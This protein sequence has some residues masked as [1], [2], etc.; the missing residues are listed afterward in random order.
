MSVTQSVY[1]N[2]DDLVSFATDITTP[3][4]TRQH[5][6]WSGS[7]DA[8]SG[9]LFLAPDAELL[10]DDAFNTPLPYTDPSDVNSASQSVD[11]FQAFG[12]DVLWDYLPPVVWSPELLTTVDTYGL[13]YFDGD[14]SYTSASGSSTSAMTSTSSPPS[15]W[16]DSSASSPS[17]DAGSPSLPLPGPSRYPSAAGS[18]RKDTTRARRARSNTFSPVPH[19]LTSSFLRRARTTTPRNKQVGFASTTQREEHNGWFTC[20]HCD[21]LTRRKG[22]FDRHVRT[23]FALSR[24]PEWVCCGVP[25]EDAPGH[26]GEKYEHGGR[27]M[28]GGCLKSFSRRDS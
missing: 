18:S 26:S 14:I 25:E 13:P 4:H 2:H 3:L 22:D 21:F 20:S 17:F 8:T 19:T 23:H 24:G 10:I 28:V 15:S 16:E 9:D 11:A 27:R 5:W 12:N 1:Y 6:E 7:P